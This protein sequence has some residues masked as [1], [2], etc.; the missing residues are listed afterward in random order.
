MLRTRQETLDSVFHRINEATC[1]KRENLAPTAVISDSISSGT[2]P[3]QVKIVKKRLSTSCQRSRYFCTPDAF[4][5]SPQQDNKRCMRTRVRSFREFQPEF[6]CAM[7]DRAEPLVCLESGAPP[8]SS[9]SF[10][11]STCHNRKFEAPERLLCR[12]HDRNF[13]ALSF[14]EPASPFPQSRVVITAQSE[15]WPRSSLFRI[16]SCRSALEKCTHSFVRPYP[17]LINSVTSLNF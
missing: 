10:P 14:F 3:S 1:R 9:P 16:I 2:Q 5:P 15:N 8:L 12:F 7:K 11:G 17:V 6:R 13:P 4:I